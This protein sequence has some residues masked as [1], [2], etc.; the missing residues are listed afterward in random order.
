V[1]IFIVTPHPDFA[2]LDKI[3]LRMLGTLYWRV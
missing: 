2:H 3:A 1:T